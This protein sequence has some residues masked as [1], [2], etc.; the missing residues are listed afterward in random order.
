M[1][2]LS[3]PVS[4]SSALNNCPLLTLFAGEGSMVQ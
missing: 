2:D 3:I 1:Y 4:K